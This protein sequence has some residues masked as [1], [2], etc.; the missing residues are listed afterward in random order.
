MKD[1]RISGVAKAF[2]P[3]PVL[4]GVDLSVPAGS[5]TAILG[6]VGEREDDVAADCGGVRTA[7]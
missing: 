5:F 7:R 1:L 3:Q 4:R 2:G 6:V